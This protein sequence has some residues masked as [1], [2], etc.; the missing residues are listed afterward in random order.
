M[1]RDEAP[2]KAILDHIRWT[3]APVLYAQRHG[4]LEQDAA[5]F[6]TSAGSVES[7]AAAAFPRAA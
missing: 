7:A 6:P 2:Y 3:P 5:V 4:L 1:L